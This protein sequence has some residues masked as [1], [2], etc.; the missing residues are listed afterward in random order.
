MKL[1]MVVAAALLLASP[2]VAKAQD[3][4]HYETRIVHETVPGRWVE[5]P[6]QV[7]HAGW[8]EVRTVRGCEGRLEQQRIEHPGYYTTVMERVWVAPVTRDCERR[9]WVAE[10][11]VVERP[12]VRVVEPCHVGVGVG[13]RVGRHLSFG[14]GF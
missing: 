13:V 4:G 1:A 8:C 11:V 7:W 12:C 9:V 3:C 5:Q 6:R 14:F 10:R 2:A